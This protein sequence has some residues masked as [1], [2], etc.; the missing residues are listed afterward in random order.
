MLETVR[1]GTATRAAVADLRVCAKTG[2]AQMDG[3]RETN[4]WV[5][6]F[7]D[8]PRYP[9]AA[10]VVVEDAGAG[11]TMAAPIMGRLFAYI[12]DQGITQ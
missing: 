8:D 4:A 1:R 6:G 10:C 2:S 3:Q 7:I 12:H 11:G 5:I 9:Y